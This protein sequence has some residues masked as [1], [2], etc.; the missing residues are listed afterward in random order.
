MN[1]HE[2]IDV[3]P[4]A[5]AGKLISDD[6]K[7]FARSLDSEGYQAHLDGVSVDLPDLHGRM[8]RDLRPDSLVGPV[9]AG[10]FVGR[11][12]GPDRPTVVYVHGTRERPFSSNPLRN[13]FKRVLLDADPPVEA[14]LV[15]VRAPFHTL[16][17]RAYLDRLTDAANFMAMLAVSVELV[18]RIVARLDGGGRVVVAGLSLGG[19][20]ANLHRAFHDSADGYA[21]MLA[22]TLYSDVVLEGAFR[23]VTADRAKANPGTVRELVDFEDEFARASADVRPLLARHDANVRYEPQ[24]RSYGGLS[25]QTLEK[26]HLTTTMATDALREHV[27]A[28]LEGRARA[29]PE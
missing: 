5:L 19:F 2:L 7:L 27:L 20:V 1:R 22:G 21:P 14:N 8:K 6:R 18:E 17:M 15:A 23:R 16:G 12:L 3:V 4:L 26:G 13:S 28:G 9:D 25:V 29:S 10:V 24:R 11:W